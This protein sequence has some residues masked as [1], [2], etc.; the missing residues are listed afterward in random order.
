MTTDIPTPDLCATALERLDLLDFEDLKGFVRGLLLCVVDLHQFDADLHRDD[1]AALDEMARPYGCARDLAGSIVGHT[2]PVTPEEAAMCAALGVKPSTEG[3]LSSSSDCYDS[4]PTGELWIL[5]R[6]RLSALTRADRRAITR[7]MW[8]R[9]VIDPDH[10]VHGASMMDPPEQ[11]RETA[12][13]IVRRAEKR[14]PR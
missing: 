4:M 14:L 13:S 12:L 8:D 11:R 5:A 3:R 7:E 1:V 9:M 2:D 10:P 6:E